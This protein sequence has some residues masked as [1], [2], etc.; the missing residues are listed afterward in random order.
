MQSETFEE[1][2]NVIDDRTDTFIIDELGIRGSY[3]FAVLHFF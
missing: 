2:I 3:V 1:L